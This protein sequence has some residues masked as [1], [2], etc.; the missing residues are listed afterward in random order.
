MNHKDNDTFGIF[1]TNGVVT[2]LAVIM[3]TVGIALY[4]IN[5]QK[6]IEAKAEEKRKRKEALIAQEAAEKAAKAKNAAAVSEREAKK[7]KLKKLKQKRRKGGT[8]RGVHDHALF[9]AAVKGHTSNITDIATPSDGLF[10][11]ATT[12]D[13]GDRSLRITFLKKLLAGK[14]KEPKFW[15]VI[16][17]EGDHYSALAV[18]PSGDCL[19]AAA[20]RSLSIHFYRLNGREA[21]PSRISTIPIP[22]ALRSP[23]QALSYGAG[24]GKAGGD[25]FIAMSCLKVIIPKKEREGR[26]EEEKD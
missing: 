9:A 22:Q 21:A 16:L 23:L 18:A 4:F 26:R 17:P 14:S 7:A 20:A 2:A 25:G 6:R 19:V 3:M 12:A 24:A 13:E 15:R 1:L 8:E 5:D 10:F 11:V